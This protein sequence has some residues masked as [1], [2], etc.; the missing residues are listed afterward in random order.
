M[1]KTLTYGDTFE[2]DTLPGI[3]WIL[4]DTRT[5]EKAGDPTE[6]RATAYP[7]DSE[8]GQTTR[9]AVKI[10]R[11]E[12]RGVYVSIAAQHD[13]TRRTW[14][15]CDTYDG[16]LTDAQR[17][18]LDAAFSALTFDTPPLTDAE[19]VA[20]MV[21]AMEYAGRRGA[22]ESRRELPDTYAP[23][24]GKTGRGR[25]SAALDATPGARQ[26][27]A[28]AAAESYAA[29]LAAEIASY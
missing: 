16:G 3:V 19:I 6:T 27:M 24:D 10:G 18:L 22:R 4:Q 11:A 8:T 14:A 12:R 9:K 13:G 28:T 1:S 15:G 23:R 29:E 17:R 21:D 26:A 25:I 2:V 7:V 20:R 5:L